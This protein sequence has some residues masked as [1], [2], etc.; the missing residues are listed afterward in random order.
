MVTD[1]WKDV[2]HH[3]S[4]EKCKLKAQWNNNSHLSEWL[5]SKRQETTSVGEDVEKREASYSVGRNINWQS[6]YGEQYEVP[7]NITNRIIQSRNS[8][9]E[10][11]FKEHEN[12]NSKRYLYPYVH[13]NTIYTSQDMKKS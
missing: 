10:Y 9:S 13:C 4:S 8:T 5:L 3:K 11:L 1:A 12:T 6:H 2:Q 7:Q